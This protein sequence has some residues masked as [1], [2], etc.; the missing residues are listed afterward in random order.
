M[1]AYYVGLFAISAVAK[2]AIVFNSTCPTG[3]TPILTNS[4]VY[5]CPGIMKADSG[6]AY[7]C[8]GGNND[9]NNIGSCLSDLGSCRETI[10]T[11]D[12]DYQDKV[13]KA[14]GTDVPAPTDQDGTKSASAKSFPPILGVAVAV[15]GAGWYGL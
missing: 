9:C 8:I 12:P 3:Q 4:M 13:S 10:N 11:N 6:G 7:C 15:V 5:C 1:K 2:K 14:A